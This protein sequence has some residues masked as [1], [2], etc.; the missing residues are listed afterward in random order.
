M[1]PRERLELQVT[2]QLLAAFFLTL[3]LAVFLVVQAAALYAVLD[4]VDCLLLTPFAVA[5][6]AGIPHLDRACRRRFIT[7]PA[8]K[9]SLLSDRFRRILEHG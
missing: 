7:E 4:T 2:A 3:A 5:V 8:L 9:S 6:G 1:T